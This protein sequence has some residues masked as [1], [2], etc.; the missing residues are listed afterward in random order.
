MTER[1]I[2]NAAESCK[3]G[4]KN[5]FSIILTEPISTNSLSNCYEKN[6]L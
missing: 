3:M 5:I 6:A 1:K 4:E 2:I